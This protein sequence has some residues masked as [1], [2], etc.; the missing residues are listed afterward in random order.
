MIKTAIGDLL[1]IHEAAKLIGIRV[2]TLYNHNTNGTGPKRY[3]V[4]KKVCYK[5]SDL[6]AWMEWDCVR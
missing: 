1:E 3:R 2:K 5:E 4:G 6:R